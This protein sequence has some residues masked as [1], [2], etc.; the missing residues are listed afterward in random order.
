[1]GR[2]RGWKDRFE[3]GGKCA[4][5]DFQPFCRLDLNAG[6]ALSSRLLALQ[7]RGAASCSTCVERARPR[8]N[9]S[10]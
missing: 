8:E 5:F 1:M 3:K 9:Q 4:A 2:G 7:R 6:A 10:G